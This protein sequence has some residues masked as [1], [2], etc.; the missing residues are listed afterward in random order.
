MYIF[1][2]GSAK[3]G[4]DFSTSAPPGLA[5]IELVAAPGK[6]AYLRIDRLEGT[7]IFGNPGSPV[8]SS[9]AG[10]DAIVWVLDTNAPRTA[11]LYGDQAPMPVLY[12]FD[13]VTLKLLWKSAPGELA[14]SGKYNEPAVA[15]GLVLVG[16]DRVQAFGLRSKRLSTS[17]VSRGKPRANSVAARPATAA[18]DRVLPPAGRAPAVGKSDPIAVGR[19]IF[20]ARCA[21]CHE[22]RQPG[23]PSRA[24]LAKLPQA[25]IVDIL[26]RG[27]M[28]PMANGLSGQDANN[29]AQFVTSTRQ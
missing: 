22:S 18:T 14:T 27:V 5:R 19:T 28:R 12:A 25:Q 8:V 23:T 3:T 21:A 6:P 20:R 2:S 13:A 1:A 9:A 26:L 15:D 4:D 24:D 29:V 11:P 16:T 10:A 17:S 7:Q